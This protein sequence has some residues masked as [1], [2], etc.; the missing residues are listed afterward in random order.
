[1]SSVEMAKR[2]MGP[3]SGGGFSEQPGPALAVVVTVRSVCP[4][5]LVGET[6]QP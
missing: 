4:S 3:G 5:A 2:C 1:M 6:R